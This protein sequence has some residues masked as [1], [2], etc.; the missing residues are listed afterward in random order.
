MFE[1]DNWYYVRSGEEW[2]VIPVGEFP[3]TEEGRKSAMA[4]ADTDAAAAGKVALLYMDSGCLIDLM[5]SLQWA[6]DKTYPREQTDA[7]D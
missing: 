6:F 3:C 7:D 4:A 2:E 5:D 1:T